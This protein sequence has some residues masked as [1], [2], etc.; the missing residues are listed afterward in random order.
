MNNVNDMDIEH[1]CALNFLIVVF[2][3]NN[4]LCFKNKN[5]SLKQRT[6]RSCQINH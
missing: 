2:Q 6:K 3:Q 5:K 4:D 1:I